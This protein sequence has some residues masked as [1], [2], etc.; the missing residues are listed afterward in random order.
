MQE[1]EFH[2]QLIQRYLNGTATDRELEVFFSLLEKGR[3]NPTLEEQISVEYNQVMQADQLEDSKPRRM[4]RW[5]PYAAAAAILAVLAGTWVF[6]LDGKRQTTGRTPADE[7]L[8][9]AAIAP[10]GNRAILSLADGRTID[11]SEAENG[12]IV[13][14][15]GITYND[16]D[17]LLSAPSET[18]VLTTPKGGTYQVTLSDGT[19]VWLNAAS[20]LR[21]PSRFDKATRA[22]EV[23]GEAYFA[24]ERDS[25]RPFV[26]KTARQVIEVLGTEFNVAAYRDELAVKT[27]LINGSVSV[28]STSPSSSQ[29]K[30]KPG[31]QSV[32]TTDGTL[33][34][35][36]VD[37]RAETAWKNG[38]VS[39][40]NVPFD[41]LM[42]QLA[43]WY[44]IEIMYQ[45]N[46]PNVRFEGE[47]T[48]DVTLEKVL[49]FFKDS[50]VVFEIT[51]DR[52]L[53]VKEKK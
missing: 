15:E 39:L 32:L 44:N 21:Y 27:T 19:K 43:R 50:G 48:R 41:E 23:Y 53:I 42:R 40:T 5:L 46:V 51:N 28:K 7:S 47:I 11:L 3:I 18:L 34:T 10:G 9:A 25:K 37:T 20:T 35:A 33:T 17:T 38:R 31:E 45:G 52:K 29:A 6:F 30:L 14:E 16:G 36:Q 1:H 49:D 13:G 22:V 24:V 2:R 4:V 26:V 8:N 12:I